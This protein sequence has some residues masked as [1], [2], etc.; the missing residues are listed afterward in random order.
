MKNKIIPTIIAESQKDIDDLLNKYSKD[1]KHFQLDIM[2][3][4]FVKNKSNWFDFKLNKKFSYEA[5][6]MLDNPE[7]WIYENY[8]EFVDKTNDLIFCPEPLRVVFFRFLLTKLT[9][10]PY[11]TRL[12]KE[13]VPRPWYGFPIFNSLKLAKALGYKKV[14]IIEFGVAGGSGLVNI[15]YHVKEIQKI[16]DIEVEIYGFDSGVGLPK[17]EDYRDLPYFWKEGFLQFFR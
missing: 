10:I 4:K 5:H 17:L 9:F 16:I 8:K 15:E 1:F 12:Y 6:L 2:D 7:K 13:A 11:S 14:S 3:S